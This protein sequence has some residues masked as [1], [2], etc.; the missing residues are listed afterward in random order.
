MKNTT[1]LFLF[2]IF[3]LSQIYGQVIDRPNVI[4]FY[5]DDLG[6]QDTQL[7][8][9]GTVCPWETPNML[10]LAASGANFTQ[11]YSP[12]PTCA[13]SRT[14]MM[15]GRHT[16]QTKMTHVSGGQIPEVNTNNNNSKM[17]AP[18]YRGRLNLE[19]NFNC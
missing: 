19:R 16:T 9:E 8:D 13:P 4:V 3:F 17:I 10:D 11:A 18:Y 1:L 5:V 2:S 12:A 7:N 14:A 6:W 15:S